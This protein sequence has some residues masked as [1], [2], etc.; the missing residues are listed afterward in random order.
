MA[1]QIQ[2]LHTVMHLQHDLVIL[3]EKSSPFTTV[4][5]TRAFRRI[6]NDGTNRSMTAIADERMLILLIRRIILVQDE[7]MLRHRR[8]Q[9]FLW[10]F[11]LDEQINI[12]VSITTLFER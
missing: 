12:A 9:P 5:I 6:L 4:E 11:I 3:S 8:H 1:D 2:G 7:K 10:G